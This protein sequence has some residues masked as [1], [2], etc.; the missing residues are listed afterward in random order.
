MTILYPDGDCAQK[1]LYWVNMRQ[2]HRMPGSWSGRTACSANLTVGAQF[3]H[4]IY[5]RYKH[6]EENT[7][8]LRMTSHKMLG[9]GF[10]Q[11]S[12]TEY[13]AISAY[14]KTSGIFD[15]V[16]LMMLFV[17]YDETSNSAHTS[18]ST[19][20]GLLLDSAQVHGQSQL[21]LGL[22]VMSHR[23]SHGIAVQGKHWLSFPHN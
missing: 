23:V 9:Y 10:L 6:C 17:T 19:R 2:M 1:Y 21:F 4:Y 14:V 15:T 13:H 5:P 22:K 20:I 18:T 11:K 3:K 8:A 12:E 7:K 16:R